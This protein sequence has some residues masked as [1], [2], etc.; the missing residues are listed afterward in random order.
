MDRARS[1]RSGS[2][3]DASRARCSDRPRAGDVDL[4]WLALAPGP[5]SA[6]AAS[7]ATRSRIFDAAELVV[8]ENVCSLPLN[9]AAP[10]AA[11]ATAIDATSARVVLHHHDLPWQRPATAT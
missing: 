11:I 8:V 1:R 9:L 5:T 7:L 6:A 10:R 2:R 4:P 3:P